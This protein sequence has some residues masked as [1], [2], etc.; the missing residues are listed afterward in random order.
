MKWKG[1]VVVM[2]VMLLTTG[3]YAQEKAKEGGAQERKG[4][5]LS[6]IVVTETKS[7]QRQDEVTHKVDVVTSEDI[8]LLTSANR[9]LTEIFLYQPGTFINP[10]S[11]NDANWGSYGGLGPKYNMYLLDGLPIDS[12]V[13]PMALDPWILQR[14]EVH[15][16]PAA[17]MYPNYLTQDF[18]GT[19]SAL[20]GISNL[21]TKE[22]M[23]TRL[24]RISLGYG[25][26][27]TLSGK[28]YHQGSAGNFHYFLGGSYEQSDYT[29]YGTEGSW[30]NM[31]DDPDYKKPKL[32]L[33]TTY[34][35]D[36][37]DHK[38]SLFVNH[39]QHTGDV[40]RPNRDYDHTYDIVNLAYSN[41]INNWLNA[42]FK[43]GY[44]RYDR[45][46]GE[47]NYPPDLSLRSKDGVKQNIVPLDLSFGIRHMGKS[48]LTVGADYQHGTYETYSTVGGVKSMG[49]DA[50]A[51]SL[52]IYAQEHLIINNWVVR[53]GGRFSSIKNDYDL[54]SGVVPEVSSKSWDRF[55]GSAGVRYNA[56]KQLGIYANVGTSFVPPSAKSVGGTLNA[57]DLGVPGRNGQL[58]NPGLGPEKGVG[59]DVGIDYQIL[60]NL[61]AGVRGFYNK[62]DDVIVENRV[63]ENPSQSQSVNAGNA[64]SYGIELQLAHYI[65][66]NIYWFTNYSYID[67]K[68]KNGVDPDQDG[69]DI[70]FTPDYTF[71]VG[72]V[73]KLPYDFTVAPYLR[74]VGSYY[75]S[76][77]LIGRKKFGAYETI[78]VKIQKLLVKT[79]DYSMNFNLDL[80]NVTD[81][82]Y[83]MPWQFQNTGFQAFASIELIF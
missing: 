35:F 59:Y 65:N 78:N 6:E 16:G 5:A 8:D 83:E 49:N 71:N 26:W 70:P 23:D 66:Q 38:I 74:L 81:N 68:I 41:Q 76:T 22:R 24:T 44:R 33:K 50:T 7:E 62:V 64:R 82:K 14:A 1:V 80:D 51:S 42:Q 11:R 60:D 2:V 69:A 72:L 25:S 27:D 29:N 39:A 63:S 40:G 67:T 55:L 19:E 17:V 18:A 75:D 52:G 28:I 34:F 20:A 47:D 56:S 54:L 15:R 61:I 45:Q 31:L 58:P 77:S 53:L 79:K 4:Y 48:L 10:L 32:Y 12:F 46:W 21:I 3:A 43:L 73:A 30:L 13:D 36:R 37:D 9:N 57:S